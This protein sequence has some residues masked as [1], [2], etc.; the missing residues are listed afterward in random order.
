MG[1]DGKQVQG[2]SYLPPRTIVT[3]ASPSPSSPD[4]VFEDQDE[5]SALPNALP[6]QDGPQDR[7]QS[8]GTGTT[9]TA[10]T[11]G[12]QLFDD[13]FSQALEKEANSGCARRESVTNM[14]ELHVEQ[15][16]HEWSR[17]ESRGSI[18]SILSWRSSLGGSLRSQ[19]GSVHRART[20]GLFLGVNTES[21]WTRWSRERRASFHRKAQQLYK[22][23][24]VLAR[25]STPVRKA[26]QECLKFVHPDLETKMFSEEDF[27][28]LRRHKQ[29]Q[30]RAIWVIEKDR[31]SKFRFRSEVQLT[32]EQRQIISDFWEHRVFV[33]A[34]CWGLLFVL[35]AFVTVTMSVLHSHWISYG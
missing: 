19:S 7:G 13:L 17:R 9:G 20:K 33:R 1:T 27:Q 4:S 6:R 22:Q 15:V 34:R 5:V 23:G 28:E 26:R 2:Q 18:R 8:S 11:A 14:Q 32:A 35:L 3:V 16:N 10:G 25:V 30:F 24:E 29:R 12:S 21:A 31:K